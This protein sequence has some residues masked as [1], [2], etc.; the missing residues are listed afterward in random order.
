[1]ESIYP[2]NKYL[3]RTDTMPGTALSVVWSVVNQ[4]DV[5]TER[6]ALLFSREQRMG[7]SFTLGLREEGSRRGET[8]S[9][10]NSIYTARM[11]YRNSSLKMVSPKKDL[12]FPHN[13]GGSQNR[14]WFRSI[15]LKVA[16]GNQTK[17]VEIR[18]LRVL[19]LAKLSFMKQCKDAT[20]AVV[21]ETHAW[22]SLSS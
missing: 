8:H 12:K 16:A 20:T 7:T 11:L 9:R 22:Q 4:T 14:C 2:L 10:R 15:T 17:I 3:P 1:M 21:K 18:I 5:G 19:Q 13:P 6:T